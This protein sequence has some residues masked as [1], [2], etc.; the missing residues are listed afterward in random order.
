M[1]IL[2]RGELTAKVDVKAH[3]F[4]A[5][6]CKSR[7]RKSGWYNLNPLIRAYEELHTDITKHI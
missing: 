7:N 5:S 1:K 4:S 6:F 3:A 2:G